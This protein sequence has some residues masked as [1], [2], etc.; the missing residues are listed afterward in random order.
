MCLPTN[1]STGRSLRLML[2]DIVAEC[3]KNTL[4]LLCKSYTAVIV[5]TADS[6]VVVAV[7]GTGSINSGILNLN[8]MLGLDMLV[9]CRNNDLV[10]A[11]L[12]KAALG[13][14]VMLV[15]AGKTC[16][17]LCLNEVISM[18][19]SGNNG[20]VSLKLCIAGITVVN[21]V[22]STVYGTGRIYVIFNNLCALGMSGCG[23]GMFL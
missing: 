4:G 19:G 21:R 17:S 10:C 20:E 13:A 14:L 23:D 18:T 3:G 7:I 12:N 15:P 9:S 16:G 8:G 5:G 2:Y 1:E 11:F 22:V 6:L